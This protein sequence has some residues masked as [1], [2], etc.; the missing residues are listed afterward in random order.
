M[1]YNFDKIYDR[2]D[3]ASVKW[4]LRKALYGSDE[5]IPLWV[6]DMDFPCPQPVIEALGKRLEHPIFGYSIQS[7]EYNRAVSG[8]MERRFQWQLPHES[9]LYCPGVVPALNFVIKAYTSPGD[10]VII[11]SPVYHIFHKAILNN[12][13]V[14]A[15]NPLVYEDGRYWM[16]FEQLESLA[17]EQTKLMILCSPHNPVGRVWERAELLKVAEF[18]HKNNIILVSDEIHGDLIYPGSR[19]TPLASLSPEI[20]GRII[21]CTAPSKTFNLAGLQTANV[22]I[23]DESLRER[24]KFE[25]EK[26]GI[27]GPS[28]FGAAALIA[29]YNEG[30]EWLEQMLDYLEGNLNYLSRFIR[31]ELPELEVVRPE[32]TYLIW[33]DCRKLGMS[34]RELKMFMREKAKLAI[35]DGYI[36]GSPGTGFIRINIACPRALLE[37]ALGRLKRALAER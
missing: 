13:R 26:S 5:L 2:V 1:K 3:T 32:A 34:R 23:E 33:V 28:P 24:F 16:D 18:C 21:T 25:L 19:H 4:D 14:I 9:I 6:A 15:D 12:D 30:E 31:E 35:E 22:I 8:W 27:F 17:G 20:A 37:E 7:E 29:A 11:Q 36:F 10:K